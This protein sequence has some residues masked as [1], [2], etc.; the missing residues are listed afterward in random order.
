MIFDIL[1]TII[2]AASGVLALAFII[3]TVRS[4]TTGRPAYETN[5]IVAKPSIWANMTGDMNNGDEVGE[6]LTNH[7][8]ALNLRTKS[9]QPQQ[10]LSSQAID[11]VIARSA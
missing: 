10:R 2:G 5:R 3:V 11:D 7:G 1:Y 4:L 9:L 8:L 6:N